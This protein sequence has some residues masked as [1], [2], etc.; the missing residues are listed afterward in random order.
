MTGF[1]GTRRGAACRSTPDH[2]D[3]A[4]KH[5]TRL[6]EARVAP[7]ARARITGWRRSRGSVVVASPCSAVFE[8]R[9]AREHRCPPPRTVRRAGRRPVPSREVQRP[10]HARAY[11]AAA[12]TLAR[13]HLASPS[14]WCSAAPRADRRLFRA[15]HVVVSG[16]LTCSSPSPAVILPGALCDPAHRP[17]KPRRAADHHHCAH[18]PSGWCPSR[19]SAGSRRRAR[20]RVGTGILAPAAPRCDA[21]PIIVREVLPNMSR[22][23]VDRVALGACIR[24][25]RHAQHPRPSVSRHA[26]WGNIS[27]RRSTSAPPYVV[28]EPH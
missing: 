26:T 19:C 22:D 28:F 12:P 27:P 20:S 2:R 5:R 11:L 1:V 14:A 21:S 23:G 24:R 25:R 4:V 6:R 13:R 18:L 10:R 15:G 17:V 3:G 16:L 7:R 8:S 9:P